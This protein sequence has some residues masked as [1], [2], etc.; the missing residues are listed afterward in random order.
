MH[1]IF[2]SA[3]PEG[4]LNVHGRSGVSPRSGAFGPARPFGPGDR[5]RFP[6]GY[7]NPNLTH[8]APPT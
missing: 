2:G 3:T 6:R 7:A 1:A 5:L 4:I 8:L